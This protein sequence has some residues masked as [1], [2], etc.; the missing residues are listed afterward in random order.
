VRGTH[1]FYFKTIAA[2]ILFPRRKCLSG[3]TR[4]SLV[5]I[6][7]SKMDISPSPS[8]ILKKKS[9]YLYISSKHLRVRSCVIIIIIAGRRGGV[10]LSYRDLQLYCS[11]PV[12]GL[13]EV[14]LL[15]FS[16]CYSRCTPSSHRNK[17]RRRVRERS[18]PRN[19]RSRKRNKNNKLRE[20]LAE[21]SSSSDVGLFMNELSSTRKLNR[22]SG[23]IRLQYIIFFSVL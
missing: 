7:R 3:I 9:I 23:S 1:L 10:Y 13:L 20:F 11:R 8:I 21:T 4:V 16:S 19:K 22:H 6:V 17:G 14:F 15:C 5:N 12:I 18:I 2:G